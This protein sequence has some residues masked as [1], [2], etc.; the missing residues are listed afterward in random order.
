MLTVKSYQVLICISYNSIIQLFIFKQFNDQTVLFDSEIEPNQ[1]LPFQVR[2]DLG[3]MARKGLS[4]FPKAPG[5]EP[6]YQ[7]VYFHIQ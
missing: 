4:T 2:V 3:A 6:H 5:L 7:I 1:M